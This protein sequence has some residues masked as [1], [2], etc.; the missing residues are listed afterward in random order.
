VADGADGLVLRPLRPGDEA[1]VRHAQ[2]TMAGEGFTFALA[3]DPGMPFDAYV[4]QIERRR[5]GVDLPERWVPSTF[6]VADVGGTIVGRSSIRHRLNEFL[7]HE[8]GHIGYGVLAPY[9]R[10]GYA[11]EILRQS[12]AIV[13]GLGVVRAL[14]TC[15]DDNVASARTIERCGGVLDTMITGESGKPLRRYWVPTDSSGRECPES[16]VRR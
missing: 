5:Q 12:L 15:D 11:T 13:A 8:G 1:A 16:G 9:R 6:L 2:E 14:V 3:Y 7:A 10:R 4:A